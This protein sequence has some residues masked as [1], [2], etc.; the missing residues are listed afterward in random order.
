MDDADITNNLIA[1]PA[2]NEE[3][4][5]RRVVKQIKTVHK[6]IPVLVIDD[7]STDSTAKEAVSAGAILIRHPFN[8]G[9]AS[10]RMTSYRYAL[11][12]GYDCLIQLDGDGQHDPL[13]IKNLLKEKNGFD[14]LNGSRFLEKSGKYKMSFFRNSGRLFFSWL[15]RIMFKANITD[16]TSGFRLIKKDALLYL[17]ERDFFDY[18][19]IEALEALLRGG[20]KVSEVGV[21]M[22]PRLN[23]RSSIDFFQAA[24]YMFKVSLAFFIMVIQKEKKQFI[25]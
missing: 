1:I 11:D 20:F 23:G 14:L 3:P 9:I 13:S 25:R 4:N 6:D 7:G 2:F 10:S 16:P 21:K 19:E 15:F 24:Y 18:P 12:N 22:K 8:M 17:I 5:I